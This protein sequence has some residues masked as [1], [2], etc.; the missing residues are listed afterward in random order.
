MRWR[1]DFSDAYYFIQNSG[2]AAELEHIVAS[3]DSSAAIDA[4]VRLGGIPL[5]L[6]LVAHP[7]DEISSLAMAAM[8][9]VV[10]SCV[11]IRDAVVAHGLFPCLAKVSF[12]LDDWV[13]SMSICA[14]LFMS[15]LTSSI[16][17]TVGVNT[18]IL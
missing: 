16:I 5:L 12:K 15:F 8:N 14:C 17:F 7:I 6:Q 2:L 10:T 11:E 9:R 3:L 13:D 4:L 1:A 18:E